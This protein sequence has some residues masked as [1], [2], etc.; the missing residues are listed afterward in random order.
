MTSAR[1]SAKTVGPD[2]ARL[3]GRPRHVVLHP[4]AQGDLRPPGRHGHRELRRHRR[5]RRARAS[6][7]ARARSAPSTIGSIEARPEFFDKV[8][9]Y[10]DHGQ[11]AARQHV[12]ALRRRRARPA[13]EATSRAREGARLGHRRARLHGG[14]QRSGAVRDRAESRGA[15]A[16]DP[17]AR[18]RPRLAAA[19]AGEVP[20]GAQDARADARLRVLDESRP[21]GR[22]DRRHRDARLE[23]QHPRVRVGAVGGRA[24]QAAAVQRDRDRVRARRAGRA[25]RRAARPGR[26]HRE[27]R[28][29]RRALRHRPRHPL[30]RHDH[31]HEGPR[32]VRGAGRRDPDQRAPRARE[33]H[34]HRH[35]SAREGARERRVRPV[36]PRGQ[37]ARPRV[38]RHRGA[39]HVVA[40]ARDAARCACS[41]G[42]AAC[43]CSAS[44][45]RIR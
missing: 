13:G 10:S 34:A 16:H 6:T 18:A 4:V 45:R 23:G 42:R 33:A 5:G 8:I 11:R 30:G 26:A 41:C 1:P 39:A 36:H 31:R 37:A 14:R 44:R 22:H 40:G 29:D 9:K 21:L 24:R 43:S 3:L 12:S 35:A 32:R 25:R 7:S 15:R 20:R 17:G 38:P 27:A 19:R 28:D 2:R